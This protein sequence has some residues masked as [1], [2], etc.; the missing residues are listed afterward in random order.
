MRELHKTENHVDAIEEQ[1]EGT[2]RSHLTV[3]N[4]DS[5]T[6]GNKYSEVTQFLPIMLCNVKPTS[7]VVFTV[8]KLCLVTKYKRKKDHMKPL[9]QQA[10]EN[11]LRTCSSKCRSCHFNSQSLL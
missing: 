5:P 7:K 11:I 6:T 9:Y 4:S 1:V 8:F 2:V 10:L 3:L